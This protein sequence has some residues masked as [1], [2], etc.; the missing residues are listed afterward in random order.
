MLAGRDDKNSCTLW[1]IDPSGQFWKCNASCIGR[2]AAAAEEHLLKLIS[3]DNDNHIDLTTFFRNLS[4]QEAISMACECIEHVLPKENKLYWQALT[5]R[6]PAAEN[7]NRV[8]SQVMNGNDI[9]ALL[10][11]IPNGN[12]D[13]I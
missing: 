6:S 12:T 13:G 4:I 11:S 9:V 8:T 10:N 7:D 3:T 1:R 5:L 2:G